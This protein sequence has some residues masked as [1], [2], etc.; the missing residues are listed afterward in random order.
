LQVFNKQRLGKA[1]EICLELY[2]NIRY[3]VS[4][5][6][7]LET[8]ISKIASLG[9]WISTEEIVDAIERMKNSS[10]APVSAPLAEE[11][12]DDSL[13]AQYKRMRQ[14]R[15]GSPESKNDESPVDTVLKVFGGT[16]Q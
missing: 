10:P 6:I 16:I 5:R 8:A 13:I 1:L 3:C 7:E 14:E 4:P 9:K 12:E 11:T 2:R 15:A